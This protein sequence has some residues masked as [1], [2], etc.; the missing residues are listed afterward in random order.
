MFFH[1]A[2]MWAVLALCL[3]LSFLSG[4]A[5]A[6]SE[7]GTITGVVRDSS[8]AV[9]PGAKI[10][11][12]NQATNVAISATSNDAGEFTAPNLQAGTYTVRVVKEGFRAT[13]EKGLMLDA[14]ATARA[15]ATLEIGQSTQAIE[16]IASTVSLQTD[17]A[18]SSTT[19][20]NKLVDDLPLV[21]GG[22]VRTPFDLAAMI[23]DAKNLG[24]DNGFMLGG[25]QAASYGTS[26][27]GVST[28]TSR[29]LSKSWVASN[30]P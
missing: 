5:L 14:S 23:P 17:D 28:N 8:G 2:R 15:D 24:G 10:T 27:D 1:G 11:I 4:V 3:S 7:R 26:L 9:V 25:G 6:Q 16:V 19:L 12:T 13:E 20:Q 29:A 21:V 18:K 30:S 22:T